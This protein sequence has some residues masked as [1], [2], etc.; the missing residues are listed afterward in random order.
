VDANR[1]GIGARVSILATVDGAPVWQHRFVSSQES[2][3]GA[4]LNLHFG[5]GDAA[6]VDSL[7]V[8]W[9]GG[10]VDAAGGISVDQH[11][12]LIEGGSVTS[13]GDGEAGPGQVRSGADLL[14][15]RVQPNPFEGETSV[16]F[17]L[18]ESALVELVVRDVQGRVVQRLGRGELPRG[19]HGLVW[20]GRNRAGAVV[21]TGVY[22]LALE[23]ERG[24]ISASRRVIRLD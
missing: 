11:L 4:N 19:D 20:D 23:L 13:V 17:R 7:I 16:R 10:S 2:Y 15:L 6:V 14:H 18:E 22:Y 21:P 1:S 5:L 12:V 24:W 3:C 8:R 9:P